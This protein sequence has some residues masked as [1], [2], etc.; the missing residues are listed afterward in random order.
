M[1]KTCQRARVLVHAGKGQTDGLNIRI[2]PRVNEVIYWF[3]SLLSSLRLENAA[4][5]PLKE[6]GLETRLFT[7]SFV[8]TDLIC[9]MKTYPGLVCVNKILK[10]G[11]EMT[12]TT[13]IFIDG[14]NK[15][16]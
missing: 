12:T 11:V 3:F 10:S 15:N 13:E 4:G 9:Q 7:C 5:R 8:D 2:L 16:S 6:D 14:I 1:S